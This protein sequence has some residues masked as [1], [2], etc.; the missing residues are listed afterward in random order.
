MFGRESQS[1]KMRSLY[2]PLTNGLLLL[3]I[4]NSS[5]AIVPVDV[6]TAQQLQTAIT[7]GAPYIRLT[8]HINLTEINKGTPAENSLKFPDSPGDIT[9]WVRSV[10]GNVVTFFFSSVY[11]RIASLD[12]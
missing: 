12:S 3:A 4:A 9:I 6:S 11:S 1:K 8:A 5:F 10:A 2:R 7:G